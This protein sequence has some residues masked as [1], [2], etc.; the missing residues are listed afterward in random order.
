MLVPTLRQEVHHWG[1]Y[2]PRAG[3]LG[4][5]A[6]H[7]ALV[8]TYPHDSDW[9]YVAQ[10]TGD[11]SW[12]ADKMRQYWVNFESNQYIPEGTPAAIGHGYNGYLNISVTDLN[13][14]AA[15]PKWLS[16][17]EG[18]ASLVGKS[19]W[20]N[21]DPITGDT[22]AKVFTTDVNSAAP[23]RDRETG[24]FQ[25][26]L[27]VS[28]GPRKRASPRDFI[29]DTASATNADGGRKY[30]LDIQLNTLVTRV[31]FDNSTVTPRAIGIEYMT[32][33]N[34]YRADPKSGAAKQT[35]AGVFKA[36]REVIL[37]GGV[38]NTPQLLKLSGI[39]PR[40]EL[41]SLNIPVVR[42][43]P[44]VGTNM[45]DRYE[46]TVVGEAP[47]NFTALTNCS[48]VQYPVLD[49]I[50]PHMFIDDPCLTKWEDDAADRGIYG[51]NG[52]AWGVVYNSSVSSMTEADMFIVGVPANFHGYFPE[53]S[54]AAVLNH[55]SWLVL[56]AH[57]RN[58]AGT[59]TL[60]STDP[61]DMPF[62]QFNSFLVGGDED[63]QAV[64]EGVQFARKMFQATPDINGTFEEVV[65]GG[66]Q[67]RHQNK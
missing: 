8:A 63:V 24:I 54:L 28:L 9:N 59:V 16:L 11:A 33:C 26:P 35:G 7:N 43:S 17:A 5:C 67:F 10:I 19:F 6:E 39:G 65:P 60:R 4:G 64:Y 12:S 56:K 30:K 25:I 42:D 31:L 51:T 22:L 37:S 40:A 58:N 3:T 52:V 36:T 20:P 32:G 38:Y 48:F 29:L 55:W 57:S 1:I 14:V 46:V 44:G 15:D 53:Y 21:P 41:R 23:G 50:E 45:Q 61:R 13:L 34:L 49:Y 66:L 27:S 47:D 18:S 62:A 2:Y